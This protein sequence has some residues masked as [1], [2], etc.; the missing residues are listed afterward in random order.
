MPITVDGKSLDEFMFNVR[1]AERK[2][3]EAVKR[4]SDDKVYTTSELLRQL[5]ISGSTLARFRLPGLSRYLNGRILFW[6][7]PHAIASLKKEL[8]ARTKRAEA[9]DANY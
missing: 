8:S 5:H 9:M 4:L 3:R 1:P 6:G 2:A 7:T